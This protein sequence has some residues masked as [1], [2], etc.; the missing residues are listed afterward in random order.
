MCILAF[1]D[2]LYVCICDICYLCILTMCV[3]AS[4]RLNRALHKVTHAEVETAVKL[5]AVCGGQKRWSQCEKQ[6]TSKHLHKC[7]TLTVISSRDSPQSV[8]K[9]WLRMV[10]V[11]WTMDYWTSC[12]SVIIC[13]ASCLICA[14]VTSRNYS[15]THATSTTTIITTGLVLLISMQWYLH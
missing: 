13:G 14:D 9:L 3:L 1:S 4:V 10:A 11:S 15:L 6:H 2:S 8:T 12:S 5:V 7:Q